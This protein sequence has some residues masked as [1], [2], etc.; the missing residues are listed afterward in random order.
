LARELNVGVLGVGSA[1]DVELLERPQ[2]YGY[3]SSP[4]T[5]T[6]RFQARVGNETRFFPN[7]HVKNFIGFPMVVYQD[8][9]PEELCAEYLIDVYT[10]L[11]RGAEILQLIRR[12]PRDAA[13]GREG[14]RLTTTGREVVR[15]FMYHYGSVD[16]ALEVLASY[17]GS[18]DRFIDAQI[19]EGVGR[20]RSPGRPDDRR[21][22]RQSGDRERRRRRAIPWTKISFLIAKGIFRSGQNLLS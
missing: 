18:P 7:N 19:R 14:L 2:V 3:Q 5:E 17:Q 13:D 22:A 21:R 15:S 8:G 12:P 10:N 20:I 9:D 16:E 6:L 11:R 1:G 4:E